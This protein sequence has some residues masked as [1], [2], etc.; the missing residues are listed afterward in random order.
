M[1]AHHR[2]VGH[3]R[4]QV[5]VVRHLR[6]EP[7]PDAQVVPAR[8]ALVHAVPLPVLARQ[9]APLGTAAIDPEDR[10]QEAADGLALFR[11]DLALLSQQPVHPLELLRADE[12][13]HRP[14][15][16]NAVAAR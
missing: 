12:W 1:R 3:H 11:V 9:E 4:L 5:G 16:R 6:E 8:E 10:L 7:A 13:P 14:T 2:R 15:S